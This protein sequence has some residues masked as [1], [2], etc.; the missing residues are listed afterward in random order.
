[1]TYFHAIMTYV[2][3]FLLEYTMLFLLETL[4]GFTPFE[5]INLVFFEKIICMLY[6]KPIFVGSSGLGIIKKGG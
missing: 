2:F 4:F 1:M 3:T 6:L 5:G